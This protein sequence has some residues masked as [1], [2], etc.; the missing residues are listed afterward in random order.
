MN[1][2]DHSSTDR[3]R[4]ARLKL[5]GRVGLVVLVAGL[6]TAGVATSGTSSASF[7]APKAIEFDATTFGS[8]TGAQVLF[9]NVTSAPVAAPVLDSVATNG[10]TDAF[11]LQ[12]NVEGPDTCD[13]RPV[14]QPG[15][16]CVAWLRFEPPARN[17]ARMYTGSACFHAEGNSLCV[18]LQARST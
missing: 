4:R 3:R 5:A 10:N 18:R 14:V 13:A 1:V 12:Q 6:A 11:F 9:S 17:N 2:V 8:A 16:Y 15:S 7:S